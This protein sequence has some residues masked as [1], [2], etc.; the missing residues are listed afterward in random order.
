MSMSSHIELEKGGTDFLLKML[1]T[2]ALLAMI[3]AAIGIYGLISYS[4][5]QRTH[6]IAIRMAVG[7]RARDVRRMVLR[8]GMKIALSG[9]ALGLV[10]ALPLPKVF[11]AILNGLHT[12]DPRMYVIVLIAIVAVAMLATYIPARRASGIDPMAALHSD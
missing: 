7:A 9:A 6:E 5:G 1:C 2:F 10:I 11:A 3:L 4:V 8:Q 12:G